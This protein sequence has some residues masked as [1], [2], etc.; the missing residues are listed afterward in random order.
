[1]M[2]IELISMDAVLTVKLNL[3]LLAKRALQPDLTPVEMY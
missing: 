2:G 1:M 3:D